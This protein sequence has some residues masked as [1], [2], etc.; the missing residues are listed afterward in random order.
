MGKEDLS[1]LFGSTPPTTKKG[2]TMAKAEKAKPKVKP[3]TK[4]AAA[5]K[6]A[7]KAPAKKPASN[8]AK[9]SKGSGKFYF[10]PKEREALAK[11]LAGIK[12]AATTRDIA[13]KLGEPTWKVRLAAVTAAEAK[14][15]KLV[16]KGAVL[17]I[18]PK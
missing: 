17:T 14:S 5:A 3:A 15:I 10:D 18:S 13:K 12:A 8:G 16:K 2:D 4:P 7:T 9:A 6:P 11:K 1:D